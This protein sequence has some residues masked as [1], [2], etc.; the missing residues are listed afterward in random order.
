[1]AIRSRRT[2]TALASLKGTDPDVVKLTGKSAIVM[3]VKRT[4]AAVHI[5]LAKSI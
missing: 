3:P 5:L 2:L 1:V 4:L